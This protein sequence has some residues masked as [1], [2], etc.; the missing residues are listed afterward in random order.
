[1]Q[2]GLPVFEMAAL[3][4][5]TEKMETKGKKVR[6]SNF[7]PTEIA[8]LTEK[9]QLNL[10]VIQSKFTNTVTNTI[11]YNTMFID[12]PVWALPNTILLKIIYKLIKR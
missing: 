1:M 4:G 8:I 9:V 6:K 3:S 10:D 2:W 11:Q 7:S 5:E 12:S